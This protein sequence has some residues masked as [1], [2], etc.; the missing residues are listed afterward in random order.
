MKVGGTYGGLLYN[1]SEAT[2]RRQE[3]VADLVN[4]RFR[5][6]WDEAKK[7]DPKIEYNWAAGRQMMME[8]HDAAMNE[9][10]AEEAAAS[11]SSSNA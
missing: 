3:K 10:L 6:L 8:V 2:K 9:V 1:A 5:K 7:A 4:V 11:S